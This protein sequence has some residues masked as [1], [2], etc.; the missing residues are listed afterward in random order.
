[1]KNNLLTEINAPRE[2]VGLGW[3]QDD[4]GTWNVARITDEGLRAIGFDPNAG[5]AVGTTE[6][7]TAPD[8]APGESPAAAAEATQA[9]PGGEGGP[10]RRGPRSRH[11]HAPRQP[12]RR[13]CGGA[14]RLG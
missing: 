2:H 5:D 10:P 6:S 13:R 8:V 3:R 9:A 1:M 11:C 7:T 12:P 4:E 14:G